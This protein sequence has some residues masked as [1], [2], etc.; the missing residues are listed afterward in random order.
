MNRS[1]ESRA[2]IRRLVSAVAILLSLAIPALLVPAQKPAAPAGA[3]PAGNVENGKQS[4]IQHGCFSCH[5]YSGH[6]G[7]GPRLAQNP[8]TFQSFRQYVRRPKRAMPP[9]GTLVTDSEMADI[10]AFLKTI[11]PSPDPKSITLLKD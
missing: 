1:S 10:Y 5:G 9:Y 6:G 8:I 7:T 2:S 4:F 3:A 11:P